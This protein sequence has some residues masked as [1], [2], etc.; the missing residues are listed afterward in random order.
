MTKAA[1]TTATA[2]IL[3]ATV[4]TAGTPAAAP[5]STLRADVA[6]WSIVPSQGAVRAGAVRIV[7]RNLGAEAHQLMIV[8]T[9]SFGEVLPL[10]GDRA[11]ARPLGSVLAAPGASKALVLH[12]KRGNYL[13]IDNL[14]WHYWKGTQAAFVVR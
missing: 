9:R 4:F 2:L 10:R 3:A 7:L 13:L 1:L 5:P 14:P 8:P 12:L 6:E 11:V